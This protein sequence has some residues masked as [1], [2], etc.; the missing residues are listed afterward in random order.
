[1][2]P[3]LNFCQSLRAKRPRCG[4]CG[5]L[6]DAGDNLDLSRRRTGGIPRYLF[7]SVGLAVLL[8]P[9]QSTV[10]VLPLVQLHTHTLRRTLALI[11]A[12]RRSSTASATFLA[13]TTLHSSPAAA[14]TGHVRVCNIVT[15]GDCVI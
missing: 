4:A 10:G 2:P 8:P 7:Q 11:Y 5:R 1:M 14:H 9:R 6:V 13:R 12:S 15:G 3:A